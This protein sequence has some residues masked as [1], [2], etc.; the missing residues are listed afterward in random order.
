MPRQWEPDP[1]LVQPGDASDRVVAAAH[2]VE[3]S[4]V[5]RWRA[6][7][8]VAAGGQMGRPRGT[9]WE[10]SADR[11]QP[12]HATDEE[13]ARQ[14]IVSVKTVMRWR[15]RNGVAAFGGKK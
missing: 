9:T 13:V 15:R 7:H 8:G 2:G 14:H 3:R 10:P 12:G 6:R 11:V 4:T 1:E 5:T